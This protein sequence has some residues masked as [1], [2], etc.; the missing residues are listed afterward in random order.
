MNLVAD[1]SRS[2]RPKKL[3][4]DRQTALS[5]LPHLGGDPAVSDR[6][7]D[8]SL[9]VGES[10]G[11]DLNLDECDTLYLPVCGEAVEADVVDWIH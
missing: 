3:L 8:A 11:A 7:R 5:D 10:A 2:R 4:R 6:L 9:C 1:R